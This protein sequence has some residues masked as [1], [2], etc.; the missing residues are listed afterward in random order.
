MDKQTAIFLG[1]EGHKG[2]GRARGLVF[3]YYLPKPFKC[4]F[5]EKTCLQKKGNP[6]FLKKHLL[7][8]RYSHISFQLSFLQGYALVLSHISKH[9]KHVHICTLN[10]GLLAQLQQRVS[11]LLHIWHR[12]ELAHC[13]ERQ[14][15]E[16]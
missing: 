7:F 5:K 3:L 8:N 9:L 15:E 2:G 16:H 6:D 13:A 12:L 11:N 4:F 10:L 14:L 1:T